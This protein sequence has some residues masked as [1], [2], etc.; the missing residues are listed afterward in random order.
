MAMCCSAISDSLIETSMPVHD[1]CYDTI[2]ET[3]SCGMFVSLNGVLHTYGNLKPCI[4]W[5]CNHSVQPLLLLNSHNVVQLQYSN[6]PCQ[7]CGVLIDRDRNRFT[8]MADSQCTRVQHACAQ[9]NAIT[10]IT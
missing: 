2:R 6:Y 10:I 4:I 7:F 8:W 1:Y 5:E 9:H 3:I